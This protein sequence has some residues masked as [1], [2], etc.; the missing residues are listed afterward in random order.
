LCDTATGISSEPAEIHRIKVFINVGIKTDK[1]NCMA[2]T[3]GPVFETFRKIF[4]R[5]L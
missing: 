1:M 2:L 5:L 3:W 4:G